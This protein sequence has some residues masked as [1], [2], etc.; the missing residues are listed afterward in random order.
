MSNFRIGHPDEELLLRYLDAELPARKA[1]Q[2][3]KHLDACWRCRAELSALQA[4]VDD[5]VRYE[6]NV[7]DGCEPPA[8]WGD[9]RA[10]FARIDAEAEPESVWTRLTRPFRLP[11]FR[12]AAAGMAAVLAVCAVYLQLHETPAVEAAA[13]LNRAVALA[14]EQPRKPRRI[15]IRTASRRIDLT[16]GAPAL[17]VTQHKAPPE[18]EALFLAAH[19]DWEDPL[20]ARSFQRWRD[21]VPEKQD[22]VTTVAD[23]KSPSDSYYRIRTTAGSGELASASLTLRSTDLRP[24]ESRLEFRNREW[25][26]LTDITELS[27]PAGV[28]PPVKGVEAPTRPDQPSRPAADSPMAPASISDELQVVAALHQI[29]A[30]LGDP[31][32]VTRAGSHVVVGGVGL[33]ANRQHQIR[34]HL[35]TLPNVV[36]EFSEPAPGSSASQDLPPASTAPP[37]TPSVVPGRVEQVLGGRAE[38]ERFSSQMIDW[39]ELVMARAYAL[40]GLAQRFPRES[41]AGMTAQDREL[42]RDLVREHAAAMAKHA[43]AVRSAMAPVAAS[44][45]GSSRRPQL[46]PRGDWQS[47]AEA[48]F[49]VSRRSEAL[50]SAVLGVASASDGA[51]DLPSELLTAFDELKLRLDRLQQMCSGEPGG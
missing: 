19:F 12:W 28:L 13:L 6:R 21:S 17:P 27:T 20:S 40:R 25:I 7:L 14:Q 4:T 39:T 1:R 29:G 41:A 10:G 22:E 44:L 5:C 34:E 11:A 36:V 16:V 8:A 26:E 15:Q 33:S 50:L 47:E 24:T 38:L 37:R 2:V 46:A 3:R 23:P 18:V 43:G 9:L 51:A 45:G 35:K 31:L 48:L 49:R 42:L 30:D 32:E